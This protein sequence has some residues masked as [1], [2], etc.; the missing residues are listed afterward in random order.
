MEILRVEIGSEKVELDLLNLIP[1]DGAWHHAAI[2]TS[3]FSKIYDG[4]KTTISDTAIFVDGDLHT[5]KLVKV[6]KLK[7]EE[8]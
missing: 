3:F 4:K 1:E 7:A 2:T 8:K 5:E 6:L